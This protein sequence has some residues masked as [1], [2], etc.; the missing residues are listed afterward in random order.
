[1]HTL[2]WGA[3]C[4]SVREMHSVNLQH[5][6]DLSR[7]KDVSSAGSEISMSQEITES[8][9]DLSAYKLAPTSPTAGLL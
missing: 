5:F 3:P 8:L 6:W 1:M 2:N 4:M 9:W 7:K